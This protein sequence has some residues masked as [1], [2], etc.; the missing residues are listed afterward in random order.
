M[1]TILDSNSVDLV[2]NPPDATAI[3]APSANGIQFA[4]S[5][6]AVES[7]SDLP[8]NNVE[9]QI[10]WNDGT[11]PE[12]FS[13][14]L[15][16]GGVLEIASSRNL[17]LGSHTI[18]VEASNF[19]CPPETVS[20]NYKVVVNPPITLAAPQRLI[21]GPILPRD[22][23]FPNANQWS[24]NTSEDVRILQSAIKML[25]ITTKGERVMLP[26]YGTRLRDIIFEPIG[27]GVQAMAQNEVSEALTIWE[28]RVALEFLT[29]EQTADREM[30]VTVKLISKISQEEFQATVSFAQ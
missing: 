15:S 8:S 23:G 3:R 22:E 12:Q 19:A 21:Y 7:S 26:Q 11:P 25:L 14:T 16:S 13:Y 10:Y 5:V 9:G 29:V 1:L 24:F 30:T 4:I 20:I 2:A 18:R 6:Q 27:Q 17:A 28:P